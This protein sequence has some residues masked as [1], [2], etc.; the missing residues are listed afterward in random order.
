M[1][2]E[3]LLRNVT[4]ISLY[5]LGYHSCKRK[6]DIES[7]GGEC[8]PLLPTT[9]LNKMLMGTNKKGTSMHYENPDGSL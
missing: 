2:G 3:F 1:F 8:I 4:R 7:L 5:Y 9:D 6:S